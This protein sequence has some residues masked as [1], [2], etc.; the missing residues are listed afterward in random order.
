MM[1]N[2]SETQ[3]IIRAHGPKAKQPLC[4]HSASQ[5]HTNTVQT[6][7]T[8]AQAHNI[9]YNFKSILKTSYIKRFAHRRVS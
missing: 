2:M 3:W 4:A 5:P 9:C 8:H 7:K 1:E 6:A